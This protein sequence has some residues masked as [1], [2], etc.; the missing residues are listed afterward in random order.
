[1]EDFISGEKTHAFG[2]VLPSY[3]RGTVLSRPEEYLPDYITD[4]IKTAI[5]DF[6]DWM[7]G[8]YHADAVF[9]GPET[10]STSP[11]RVLRGDNF[12]ALGLKGLYPAGEGA[13]YAG[14]IVSSAVDGIKCAEALMLS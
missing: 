2:D 6:D 10:R 9:T 4:S 3:P 13:G 14:G 8:F 7:G 1:M 12:E 5:T 11:I